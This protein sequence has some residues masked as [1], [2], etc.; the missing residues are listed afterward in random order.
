MAVQLVSDTVVAVEGQTYT[1]GTPDSVSA[2]LAPCVHRFSSKPL[3]STFPTGEAMKRQP[4]VPVNSDGSISTNAIVLKQLFTSGN[5]I[6]DTFEVGYI[7]VDERRP[8]EAVMRYR[9]EI[10]NQLPQE[11]TVTVRRA[12]G[13]GKDLPLETFDLTDVCTSKE[14]AK[15]VGMYFLSIREHVKHTCSFSTTP[16]GINLAPGD[17]IRVT[18][19][20]SPYNVANNG[21]IAADGTITSITPVANGSHEIW[22]YPTTSGVSDVYK[23]EVNIASGKVEDWDA[24][25]SIFSLVT[26]TVSQNVYKI[27][28]ITLSRENTVDIVASQFPCDEDLVSVVARELSSETNFSFKPN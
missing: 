4:A 20:T 5:I 27:E 7:N 2:L 23:V 13:D 14:H 18:T 25:A 8:F 10:K 12:G 3:Y 11:K 17:L 9:E 22:Y 28:E 26:N 16:Y 19:E 6:E 15:L 21:T 1:F 24:G